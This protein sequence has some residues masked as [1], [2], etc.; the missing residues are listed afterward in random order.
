MKSHQLITLSL[1]LLGSSLQAGLFN[2][3]P[4]VQE[5]PQSDDFMPSETRRQHHFYYPIDQLI[6]FCDLYPNISDIE[7]RAK[8]L[9]QN[10]PRFKE[11]E[12]D[13]A[14]DLNKKA[15]ARIPWRRNDDSPNVDPRM[16]DKY[17]SC[18]ALNVL[19]D[20]YR[21]DLCSREKAI[22]DAQFE[23]EIKNLGNSGPHK[24]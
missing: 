15:Y 23:L 10:D 20:A 13:L 4:R 1:V 8:N 11:A 5:K 9:L 14:N 3:N 18:R 7:G 22:L 12:D 21:R 16:Q 19:V 17:P 24:K 6:A 2:R